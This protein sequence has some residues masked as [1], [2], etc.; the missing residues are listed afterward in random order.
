MPIAAEV[1]NYV[2][3][4]GTLAMAHL[5]GPDWGLK[6]CPKG[7]QQELPGPEKPQP[8]PLYSRGTGALMACHAQSTQ[9][10]MSPPQSRATQHAPHSPSPHTQTQYL[11]CTKSCSGLREK[12]GVESISLL[13]GSQED[14]DT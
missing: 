5:E 3:N 2:L 13:S 7:R 12:N 8:Q 9:Q 4:E 14:G 10:H 11:T 1:I 6:L